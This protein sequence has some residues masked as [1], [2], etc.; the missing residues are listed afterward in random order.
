MAALSDTVESPSTFYNTITALSADI[1]PHIIEGF[2]GQPARLNALF[3]EE[4]YS[5]VT[6]KSISKDK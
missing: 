4:N 5:K 3:K 1:T 2:I 6:I